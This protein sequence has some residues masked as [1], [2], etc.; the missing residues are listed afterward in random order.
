LF[1]LAGTQAMLRTV[2][3]LST[4]DRRPRES[5]LVPSGLDRRLRAPAAV[6]AEAHRRSSDQ[7]LATGHPRQARAAPPTSGGGPAHAHRPAD[8]PPRAAALEVGRAEPGAVSDVRPGLRLLGASAALETVA[9]D[10]GDLAQ[11]R[12]CL[13]TVPDVSVLVLDTPPGMS[14]LLLSA[15]TAARV[16]LMPVRPALFSLAGTQAMLRTVA[17][18]STRDRRPRESW[19]VLSGLD[20]RLRAAAA[21]TAEARRR[22]SD[23]VLRTEIPRQAAVENATLAGELLYDYAPRAR[24]TR[25]LERLAQE[26]ESVSVGDADA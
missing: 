25:A 8:P 15:L 7:A 6:P 20:R 19:L 10:G 11:L 22:F 9:L 4:R 26:L 12:T 23:Q 2:A 1:S 3:Q 13:D 16:V 5:W 14:L 24:A 17:Q 21:V 18:L